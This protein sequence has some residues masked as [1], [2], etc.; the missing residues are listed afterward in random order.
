MTSSS[1]YHFIQYLHQLEIYFVL[2]SHQYYYFYHAQHVVEE[3]TPPP[4][5]D[6]IMNNLTSLP[7]ESPRPI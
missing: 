2:L 7:L 1:F 4:T 3:A 6:N 5:K